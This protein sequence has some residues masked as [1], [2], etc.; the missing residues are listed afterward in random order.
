[1]GTPGFEVVFDT[2][3]RD[4][5]GSLRRFELFKSGRMKWEIKRI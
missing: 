2:G 4:R 5:K 3:K 1:M